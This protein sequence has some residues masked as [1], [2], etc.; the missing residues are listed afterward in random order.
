MKKRMG[1]IWA[2]NVARIGEK[3]ALNFGKKTE[4]KRILLRPRRRWANNIKIDLK[5]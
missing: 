1:M 4:R 2:G 3:C 5:K